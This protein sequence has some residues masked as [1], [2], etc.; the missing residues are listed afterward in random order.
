MIAEYKQGKG[1]DLWLLGGWGMHRGM[2]GQLPELLAQQCCVHVCEIPGY[3][4]NNVADIPELDALV[5]ALAASAAGNVDVMGWSLGGMLAMHWASR[6]PSQIERLILIG[7][8]PSFVVR[9][10]WRAGAPAEVLGNFAIAL[11]SDA[12]ELMQ[13]FLCGLSEGEED[14]QA[15]L[16]AMQELYERFPSASTAALNAGLQWLGDIDLREQ[17]PHLP[18]K[19]LLLHGEQDVITSVTASRRMAK[20]FKHAHLQTIEACGHA[21][22]L[23]HLDLVYQSIRNFLHD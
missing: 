20:L 19:V 8:T 5:E 13:N 21:P 18:Q 14:P 4:G 11:R 16:R 9:E 6:Y 2:W 15:T 1:R 7:A 10:N 12:E 3:G 22:H 23:S 17:L